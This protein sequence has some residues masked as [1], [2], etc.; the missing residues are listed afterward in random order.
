MV[1]ARAHGLAATI[2]RGFP[3]CDEVR[4]SQAEILEGLL[5]LAG[6]RLNPAGH[7]G[8]LAFQAQ[9]GCGLDENESFASELAGLLDAIRNGAFPADLKQVTIVEANGGRAR[10]LAR[11]LDQLLPDEQSGVHGNS[12]RCLEHATNTLK[13]AGRKSLVKPHVFVSMPFAQKMDNVF[14]YG[15]QG[16]A[17]AAGFLC[18]RAD[19]STFTG[20]VLDWVK[21]RIASASLV[22]ADLST[23]N[24]NV[25]LEVGYAWGRGRPTV[26]VVKGSA[27][28]LEFNVRGH[29]CLVYQDT[30]DLKSLLRTEL[31]RLKRTLV[32]DAPRSDS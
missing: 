1:A 10:R 12:A 4:Q 22:V 13:S 6:Q 23:A 5:G 15:I 8:D 26:L 18:E 20:D 3:L 30:E 25:Y 32:V 14:H 16:A 7:T 21:A 27:E 17:N 19:Q 2:E 11:L 29:R 31:K 9:A 24:P 28:K